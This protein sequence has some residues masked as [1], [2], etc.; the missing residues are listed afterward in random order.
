MRIRRRSSNS[1]KPFSPRT[2]GNRRPR[3]GKHLPEDLPR[4]PVRVPV[5]IVNPM[6]VPIL[7]GIARGPKKG[8]R[9]TASKGPSCCD[10]GL[11]EPFVRFHMTVSKGEG[12]DDAVKNSKA[13]HPTGR[14]DIHNP[15]SLIVAARVR[16]LDKDKGLG[17]LRDFG[18]FS[19]GP[20]LPA[21]Q[22]VQ[23]RTLNS[24]HRPNPGP[25]TGSLCANPQGMRKRPRRRNT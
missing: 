8:S 22:T 20:Y 5:V 19:E 12:G 14:R 23:V 3:S 21:A 24:C 16:L 11:F 9:I 7:G 10:G 2:E 6:Q 13:I 15:G 4:F 25:G 18:V 17:G 1:M